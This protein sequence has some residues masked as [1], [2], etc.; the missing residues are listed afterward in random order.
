MNEVIKNR[1][2]FSLFFDIENGNPNGDP[3]A[4]NMPRRDPETGLGIVTDV[5]LKRKIRNYIDFIKQDA[6]GYKIYVRNGVPLDTNRKWAYEQCDV[7]PPKKDGKVTADE[8]AKEDYKKLTRFMCDNFYDIRAFGAVMTLTYNC[9]QVR[10][11]VQLGFAKSID[12]IMPQDISITSCTYVKEDDK[13]SKMGRKGI[14]PY[15]LYRVD[16]FISPCLALKETGGTGFSTEDLEL[17]W[18]ALKNMFEFDHSAARAKMSS[19]ALFVFKHESMYGNCPSNMLF[20]LITVKKRE[21]VNVPRSFY[22]Y[23]IDV[24]QD[25]IP[26]NV[27][28]ERML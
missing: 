6:V 28:L 13:S 11:P 5:C 14:V 3:D 15:A 17:F 19:R 26:Q 25:Q 24:K 27:T 8:P 21:G 22:D 7:D 12:A 1:Y 18:D 9:G 10:G 20:E 4:G 23:I 2:E 16:G